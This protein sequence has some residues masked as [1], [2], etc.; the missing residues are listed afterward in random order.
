MDERE[1][2]DSTSL[3]EPPPSEHNHGCH[4]SLR[5]SPRAQ[6]SHLESQPIETFTTSSSFS[7][8]PIRCKS[9]KYLG[10]SL[11]RQLLSLQLS[12]SPISSLP[13]TTIS[14]SSYCPDSDDENR[15]KQK[16]GSKKLKEESKSQKKNNWIQR[17]Q[18]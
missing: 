18:N 12:C 8:R 13:D 4:R 14:S 9:T 11:I 10:A 5:R 2:I 16:R 3:L 17:I 15:Q 6:A 7:Y 1:R